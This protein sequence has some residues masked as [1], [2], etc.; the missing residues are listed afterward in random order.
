ME[1]IKTKADC[2][3]KDGIK[4]KQYG[5]R[6]TTEN[7]ENVLYMHTGDIEYYVGIFNEDINKK[8]D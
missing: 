3:E 7:D 2:K 8:K 1:N 4:W 5:K 6:L